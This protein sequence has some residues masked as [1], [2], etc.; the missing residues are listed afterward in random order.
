[1]TSKK[2]YAIL[3]AGLISLAPQLQLTASAQS[4]TEMTPTQ[5]SHIEDV[6]VEK[7]E[8]MRDLPSPYS[9]EGKE[10][11]KK[12]LTP[13]TEKNEIQLLDYD[14]RADIYEQLVQYEKEHPTAHPRDVYDFFI[15][16][17]KSYNRQYMQHPVKQADPIKSD[18]FYPVDNGRVK[19]DA[20]LTR[21][22]NSDPVAGF[23][24]LLA[25]EE[26]VKTTVSLFKQIGHHDH[27][28]AFLE[29]ATNVYLVHYTNSYSWSRYWAIY[30]ASS[31]DETNSEHRSQQINAMNFNNA[32]VGRLAAA[33]NN[34]TTKSSLN[35]IKILL[36]RVYYGGQLMKLYKSNI[37]SQDYTKIFTGHFED[38]S[39]TQ[40]TSN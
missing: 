40:I 17:C 24:S 15:Q 31:I 7:Y 32:V 25:R 26:A 23:K 6:H 19:L 27:S 18:W 29:M 34:I 2:I 30:P 14:Y 22:Y 1:M 3:I 10:W 38:F 9:D 11:M 5:I 28:E 21:F 39:V 4:L 20:D 36:F 16:L 35:E 8:K 37:D 12:M 13:K 33:N